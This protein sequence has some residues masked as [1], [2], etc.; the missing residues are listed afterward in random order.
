MPLNK[1]GLEREGYRKTFA[2]GGG[3]IFNKG[4]RKIFKKKGGEVDKKG[5]EER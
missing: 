3:L 1:F 4:L 5:V 2:G